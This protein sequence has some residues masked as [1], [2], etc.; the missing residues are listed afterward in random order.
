MR[1]LVLLSTL[2]LLAA[3]CGGGDTVILTDSD[4]G[5]EFAVE[6]GDVLEISL[7]E[8]P[9]TGYTWDPAD[10]PG[11]VELTGDEF[12]DPDTDLVGAPGTRLL[13]FE[14]VS[15]GAG[16]LRLEYIRPFDEPPVA[17]RIVEFIIIA[18]DAVWPPD[19]AGSPPSTSTA[20]V[21]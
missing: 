14:V 20:T 15:E 2:A 11:L 5:S 6:I 12:V 9:S 16:I 13:S 8:N 4:S 3:S 19:P 17:D 7:E 21:P 1:H 10:P 18:G